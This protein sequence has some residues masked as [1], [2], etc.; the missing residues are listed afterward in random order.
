[1][2]YG[3]TLP[4][5]S[6]VVLLILFLF[7]LPGPDPATAAEAGRFQLLKV[8]P[9]LVRIEASK[10]GGGYAFGS[11]VVIARERVVTN[12][13]VTR[14]AQAVY[15]VKGGMRWIA[16]AQFSDPHRDICILWAPGLEATPA[17]LS[18]SA[19]LQVG[20]TVAAIG[21]GG[22]AGIQPGTGDV[23]GLYRYGG[24]MVIRSSAAFESGASGGG[25]FD[26]QGRL[27]GILTF[28]LPS[29]GAYFF[30]VPVEWIT[31]RMPDLHQYSNVAPLGARPSFWEL[32]QAEQPYFM[33]ASALEAAQA[34]S[35]LL[36]LT[37]SWYEVEPDNPDLWPFRGM[38]MERLR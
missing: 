32:S 17:I 29:K 23:A 10:V 15:L 2:A 8:A 27:V 9:S 36:R 25:L 26:E 3:E 31:D 28:R 14:E 12:C 7:L 35:D 4:N 24:A 16:R 1:M 13:H 20:Q 5:S 38:A 33:R 22:G 34:W 30:S 21:F 19:E 37:E 18:G 11:G 6:A